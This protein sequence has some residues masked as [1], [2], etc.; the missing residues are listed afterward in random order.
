MQRS[1]PHWELESH[2]LAISLAYC[3]R[4][5]ARK[6][7]PQGEP[8]R[9]RESSDWCGT[10]GQSVGRMLGTVQ[11]AQYWCT[12]EHW[13]PGHLL[14]P[15][16]WRRPRHL[17]AICAHARPFLFSHSGSTETPPPHWWVSAP[18]PQGKGGWAA[19]LPALWARS[20]VGYGGAGSYSQVAPARRRRKKSKQAGTRPARRA[21]P[22]A[23]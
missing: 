8:Q 2:A 7:R 18:F 1:Y 20:I 23:H 14:G 19:L 3:G 6:V 16:R 9:V 4:G 11:C 12:G 15:G 5:G 10:P 22:P 17:S 21:V 13:Y